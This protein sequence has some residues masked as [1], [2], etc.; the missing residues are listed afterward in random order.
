MDELCTKCFNWALMGVMFASR[1]GVSSKDLYYKLIFV[2]FRVGLTNPMFL[3]NV[4]SPKC[5]YEH[6]YHGW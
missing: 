4:E 3:V 1:E 5:K 6:M 2:D